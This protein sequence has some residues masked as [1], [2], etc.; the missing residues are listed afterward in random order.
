M[1][2]RSDIET[3][4]FRLLLGQRFPSETIPDV[5]EMAFA[6]AR[7][8]RLLN[9]QEEQLAAQRFGLRLRLAMHLAPA[10]AI[11]YEPVNP[12]PRHE[13]I[14][15]HLGSLFDSDEAIIDQLAR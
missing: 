13:L 1:P 14:R 2:I 3:L 11:A 10:R 9:A 5:D 6:L 4:F 7:T 15:E 8:I 12:T